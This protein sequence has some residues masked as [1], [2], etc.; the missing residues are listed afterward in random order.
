MPTPKRALV[1]PRAVSPECGYSL[2]LEEMI[3]P[4]LGAPGV[5]AVHGRYG[6]GKTT[7]LRH[8]GAAFSGKLALFDEEAS[9]KEIDAAGAKGL[10]VYARVSPHRFSHV[11]F[12]LAPWGPDE[13]LEYLMAVHPRHC[14]AV[15]QNL[16]RNPPETPELWTAMLDEMASGTLDARDALAQV[17]YRAEPEGRLWRYASL[18]SL[19]DARDITRAVLAGDVTEPFPADRTTLDEAVRLLRRES[20]ARQA[21]DNFWE[22]SAHSIQSGAASLLLAFD[23]DWRPRASHPMCLDRAV[24]SGARWSGVDLAHALLYR[25]DLSN[26]DLESARLSAVRAR[27]VSLRGAV[28]RMARLARADLRSADLGGA[29]LTGA[30]LPGSLLFHADLTGARFVRADLTGAHLRDASIENADFSRANLSGAQLRGL[31]LRHSTWTGARFEDARLERCRLEGMTLP[32]AIFSNADLDEAFLTAT[33]MSGGCLAGASLRG[34]K[35][36]EVTWEKADLRGADLRGAIFHMGSSRSGL[37]DSVIP[38][39]GSRTG[40]YTDDYEEQHF[41]SPEEIRKA[42]LCG[43]DLSGARIDDT[44]FYLV[45]VRGARYDAEQEAHLRRC[46]AIL[47]TRT[48]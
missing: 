21:L 25:A 18:K 26:A 6:M 41:K 38:S 14:A 39:E 45:D 8:L 48:I 37:V 40:F 7:A 28:L 32:G 27:K 19:R 29:D 9:R 31:D 11:A 16:P 36:A 1:V 13:A 17:A 34:A 24:L 33:D 15:M 20:G 22:E 2:A 43:A 42:N 44:D 30:S 3:E 10:V 35:L 12:R 46:G 4:Y 5:I 47:E 23:A